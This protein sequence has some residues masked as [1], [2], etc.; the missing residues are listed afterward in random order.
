MIR[1]L[2]QSLTK[3]LAARVSEESPSAGE[4]AEEHA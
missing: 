2:Y 3:I 4:S 1:Q